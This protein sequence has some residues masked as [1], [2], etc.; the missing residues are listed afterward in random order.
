[1][2]KFLVWKFFRPNFVILT[3]NSFLHQG[4]LPTSCEKTSSFLG[5]VKTLY[6]RGRNKKTFFSLREERMVKRPPPENGEDSRARKRVKHE[7][8]AQQP[9]F[10]DSDDEKEPEVEAS[11][12]ED[13]DDIEVPILFFGDINKNLCSCFFS[14]LFKVEH[15]RANCFFVAS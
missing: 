5:L 9:S 1:L 2:R 15:C 8:V 3:T 14:F 7:R 13:F 6:V 10:S 11:D 4:H 12:G